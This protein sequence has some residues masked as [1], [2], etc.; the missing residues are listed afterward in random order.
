LEQADDE[1]LEERAPAD[2]SAPEPREEAVSSFSV[3][4]ATE[5]APK[6]SVENRSDGSSSRVRTFGWV[7]LVFGI[8]GVGAAAVFGGLAISKGSKL[9]D[10]CPGGQCPPPEVWEDVDTYDI[11]RNVTTGTLIGGAVLATL[12]LVLVLTHPAV[13]V[14]AGEVATVQPYLG[15]TGLGLRG[16]F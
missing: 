12:G 10:A 3:A 1:A 7:S 15:T 4:P 13:E 5:P 2:R 14:T 16:S 11:Y 8:G 6:E 9:D